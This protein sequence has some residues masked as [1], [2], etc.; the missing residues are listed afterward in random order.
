M[1]EKKE[2]AFKPSKVKNKK[3]RGKPA[4]TKSSS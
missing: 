2:I 3:S 4:L 1:P